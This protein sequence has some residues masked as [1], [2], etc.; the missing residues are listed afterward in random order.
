MMKVTAY[1]DP[2]TL[3]VD[4]AQEREK[5]LVLWEM[6]KRKKRLEELCAAI[7]SMLKKEIMEQLDELIALGLVSR[8]VHVH[9]KPTRIEYA[10]TNRGAMLL[11]CLRKMMDVGIGVMMDYHM[12][13]VLMQEGYI[14][15]VEDD[16]TQT[17]ETLQNT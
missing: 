9:K 7:P 11:K 12:E 1:R 2:L 3:S 6:E 15:R 13:E 16:P 5:A 10:L 17:V 8:I 14:E 4:I